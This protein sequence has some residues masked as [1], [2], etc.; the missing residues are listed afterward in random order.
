MNATAWWFFWEGA[1]DSGFN[2]VYLTQGLASW[3]LSFE[4]WKKDRQS[5]LPT[6]Q[7]T[8]KF[9][10]SE[11]ARH[12]QACEERIAKANL[13]MT[14]TIKYQEMLPTITIPEMCTQI[15]DLYHKHWRSAKD[16]ICSGQRSQRP[17]SKQR[18]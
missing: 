14:Q 3:K 16:G 8:Q 15:I 4:T 13:E 2:L 6:H 9:M 5:Q 12:L 10:A 17:S 7:R 1:N 18:R 11:L